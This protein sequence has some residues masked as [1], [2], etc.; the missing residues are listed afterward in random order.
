MSFTNDQLQQC[1]DWL[2]TLVPE[3]DIS[4]VI[5]GL[6]D[7]NGHGVHVA[8]FLR[9]QGF[10]LKYIP[11]ILTQRERKHSVHHDKSDYLDA[12]RV[13]KVIIT[14]VSET[15]PAS[16]ILAQQPSYIRELDLLLQERTELVREQTA[17]KNQLHVLFHQHYGNSYKKEF[18]NIFSADSLAWYKQDLSNTTS[19]VGASIKRRIERLLL[20]QTQIRDITR[21][22]QI[23][24]K[25]IL[26][27][28]TLTEHIVGCGTLTACKIVSEIGIISRFHSKASLAKYSGIAPVKHQ[29]SNSNRYYI[30]SGGNRKLNQAIHTIALSQIGIAG[31]QPAKEY[32]QKKL[33]EGKSKL[34]ALRCLK[35]HISNKVFIVLK[36]TPIH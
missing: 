33:K 4:T 2:H 6:E 1:S 31:Y 21:Q 28:Q 20:T 8:H 22:I 7:T 11:A 15:L 5:V 32:Y 23:S 3:K 9:K 26:E 14:K 13:G 29:S 36:N 19:S 12:M 27:V 34:W 18:K 10:E 16:D 17:L 35:R 30:N 24:P 25:T